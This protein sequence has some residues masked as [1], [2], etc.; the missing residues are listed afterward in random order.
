[1]MDESDC[2]D[3]NALLHRCQQLAGLSVAQLAIANHM[4]IPEHPLQRK[5]FIGSLLEHALGANAGNKAVPDFESL[6][7]ELKTLSL[8]AA[9]KPAE[10]T[11]ITSIPLLSIHQQTWKT[12]SC[13]LKL[14][15]ILW[16]PVESDKNILFQHRRV[17]HAILWSPTV[18]EERVLEEDWSLFQLMLTTG[19]L[20][21]ID[22]RL[23][24]YLQI[25]PKAAHGRSLCYGFDEHGCKVKTLPRGFYLRSK[26]TAS[27]LAKSLA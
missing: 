20:A 5:G 2:L 10:S 18:E 1:M 14:K 15:R 7:V 9:G 23:G 8:N 19:R 3:E 12:S 25:R 6:G 13:F 11:F 21:E 4:V 26:F 22:A 27:I 16:V 17:G 24:S